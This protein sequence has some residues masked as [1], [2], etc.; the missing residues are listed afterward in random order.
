[1]TDGQPLLWRNALP[2]GATTATAG[3]PGEAVKHWLHTMGY[4][5][6]VDGG[7]ERC[8]IHPVAGAVAR[9]DSPLG[10]VALADPD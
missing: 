8:T 5:Y 3:L 4:R 1:M 9:L 10:H 6:P 7:P 2:G